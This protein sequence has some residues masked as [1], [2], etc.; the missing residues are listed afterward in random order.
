MIR[1]VVGLGALAILAG[2]FVYI[3]YPPG[4]ARLTA[5]KLVALDQASQ[6]SLADPTHKNFSADDIPLATD[7]T[8]PGVILDASPKVRAALPKD[9]DAKAI[10]HRAHHAFRPTKGKDADDAASYTW[11]RG[12]HHVVV[13]KD[14]IVVRAQ[15]VA[16]TK[17]GRVS[18]TGQASAKAGL[19][20][21]R[22]IKPDQK[23]K[24]SR[25]L[26]LKTLQVSR[27]ASRPA[28]ADGELYRTDEG[29]LEIDRDDHVET[30]KNK[31]DGLEQAWRFE[32]KPQGRGDL[33]VRIAVSGMRHIVTN[34]SG[35]HFAQPDKL[36]LVYGHATFIDGAG[37]RVS[38]PARFDD[39]AREIR[40]QVPN[41]IIES[42]VY[43][44]VLD[45][46]I[47]AEQSVDAPANQY[48]TQDA[49]GLKLAY[50]GTLFLAVW[51]DTR[52]GITY[53]VVASRVDRSGNTA[54]V[55]DRFGILVDE[56]V[57]NSP[58]V[59]HDVASDGTDFLV[60]WINTSSDVM[61]RGVDAA[62][63]LQGA[64]ATQVSSGGADPSNP[65]ISGNASTY[66]IVYEDR[67][68]SN[69]YPQI[70]GRYVST[71]NVP[72]GASDVVF[73]LPG[74]L[75]R[76]HP[77][78]GTNGT[79]FL[80]SWTQDSDIVGTRATAAG[81]IQDSP[82]I[83]ICSQASGQG[84]S[85]VL[86]DGTGYLVAWEDFR[87][88]GTTA[89]DIYAGRVTSAG[90]ASDAPNGFLVSNAAGGQREVTGVH[91][92]SQYL[93]GWVDQRSGTKELYVGRISNA[94][95]RSDGN[96][97]LMTT[98]D[99]DLTGFAMAERSSS[100]MMGYH[101]AGVDTLL[102]R[103]VSGTTD[104]SPA[105]VPTYSNNQYR[106]AMAFNG[107]H[108]YVAW[109][110]ERDKHAT[111]VNIYG[112]RVSADGASSPDTTAQLVNN[113]SLG[114]GSYLHLNGSVDVAS[115]GTGFMVVWVQNRSGVRRVYGRLRNADG[116]PATGA[117]YLGSSL[118]GA[119]TEL[120]PKVASNGTDYLVVWSD[121]RTLTSRVYAQRVT[122]AGT[123]LDGTGLI[124]GSGSASFAPDV[125]SNGTN[126]AV[127][128]RQTGIHA[129]TIS[130][131]G[132][133]SAPA[134]LEVSS[135]TS[136]AIESDG[137]DYLFAY[138]VTT[139]DDVAALRTTSA[140][141]PIGT[142][143]FLTSAAAR[144]GFP[145]LAF[146]GSNYL[147]AWSQEDASNQYDFYARRIT[148]TGTFPDANPFIVSDFNQS[149]RRPGLSSGGPG[150][151]L[152][153]SSRFINDEASGFRSR[154][155]HTRH[156]S[157]AANGAACGAAS[158]C[159]SGYCSD[160]VCCATDCGSSTDDCMA[161]ST[162]AGGTSTG[163]CT[164]LSAAVAPTKTCRDAVPGGCDV[165]EV[166]TAASTA[167]PMDQFSMAGTV[168]N[169]AAGACDNEETCSGSSATCPAD[170][171]KS[172]GTLCSPASC[173]GMTETS[174]STCDGA[175]KSCPMPG[176]SDCSPYLCGVSMCRTDCSTNG[177]CTSSAYCNGSVCQPKKANGQVCATAGECTSNL[178]VEGVCCNGAC[179]G[180]CESCTVGGV[181]GTCTPVNGAPAASKTPCAG[182]GTCGG[183]CNGVLRTSCTYPT[184]ECRSASCTG[185]TATLAANCDGAGSC[186]AAM[187][188]DCA[189][190]ACDG[191]ICGGGCVD[192]VDCT[193]GNYCSGGVCV[194]KKT[195][196]TVCNALNECQ[197]GF[198]ADGVC[199]DG[200]C[201]QQCEA[202]NLSGSEGTCSAVTGAPVGG[203]A[204][205]SGVGGSCGGMC[206]GSDRTGCS[207][208]GS[209]V[210]C[211]A[212]RCESNTAYE[213]AVCDGAGM[214]GTPASNTC[215]LGCAGDICAECVNDT[216]C[217][218]PLLT[219]VSGRCVMPG[220]DA[221]PG[222]AGN[223]AGQDGGRSDAS[224]QDVGSRDAGGLSLTG[225]TCSVSQTQHMPFV[226]LLTIG[227]LYGVRRKKR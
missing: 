187:M 137:T 89:T 220:A 183:S 28:I 126:Y 10:V 102:V 14:R 199:C 198:C 210:E 110:D 54:L 43:P 35:I 36:G 61:I 149:A 106:A 98:D 172:S 118:A 188:Q 122:A 159:A 193:N 174:A 208:P 124:L 49:V 4:S 21:A 219:C 88:L 112:A 40:L 48:Y 15:V 157:W 136:V 41:D 16:N 103:W 63:A 195:N 32:A 70:W 150:S 152:L 186:P 113:T 99:V 182:T 180:Q 47:S 73:H 69:I 80:V 163:T 206:D 164:A 17:R 216:D 34:E 117:L 134:T 212:A 196:G 226:W 6:T 25:A 44:A 3:W 190:N 165:A 19:P 56:D 67:R 140:L 189:P 11:S 184:V 153:A 120:A 130:A 96:G 107:T 181:A 148:P 83:S 31:K 68:I 145:A 131:A 87:N 5:K 22:E 128:W 39:V 203:R 123:L 142:R 155:V 51:K 65:S 108:H 147:A 176:M 85:K 1:N 227:V 52:L 129:S 104:Y 76:T 57:F 90:V 146:D 177:H 138:E 151:F 223:D 170:T 218:D 225:G 201:S 158:E 132:A 27:S 133:I 116:S 121:D 171:V 7:E 72:T 215:A 20:P 154:R 111:G 74:N 169:A 214:C 29:D 224:P 167:C 82:P 222:D 50:N 115:N 211:E 78:V 161:C 94:G 71:G 64:S 114:A 97:L 194:T 46:T 125:G 18:R 205:C 60:T 179:T 8:L 166:C 62:G 79:D 95:V 175:N 204:A 185:A 38:V 91:T 37:K 24:R 12:H 139:G 202:C 2:A 59:L 191:A 127:A 105:A 100:F 42:A 86:S 13:D 141:A 81:V 217:N 156:I 135:A 109:Q 75:V 197:S 178:C 160:G 162:A 192:D 55:L 92:G 45:P 207:L 77:S 53:D 33:R 173:V 209:T 143:F 144:Q 93:L 101:H 58:A 9:F 168:C 221:G 84:F 23:I 30:I 66:L 26:S 119:Q 213:A 200:T